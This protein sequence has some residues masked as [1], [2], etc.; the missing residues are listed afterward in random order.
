[1]TKPTIIFVHGAWHTSGFFEKTIA[2]VRP[3]GYRCIA[4]DLPAVGSNPPVTSL[5]EDIGPIR[6]AVVQEVELGHEVIIHAHSWGGIPT[7]S[8]LDGLS[9]TERQELK[10]T[11][12]VL[13]ITF[14]SS[15]VLP[16]GVSL[17]QAIG[18]PALRPDWWLIAE[19][20]SLN[21]QHF[22]L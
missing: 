13:K 22:S 16:V 15:F 7:T 1:M 2:L 14:V 12:G 18:G 17:E 19:D 11:G 5:T 8:A 9:S 6:A 20:V 21:R 4:V 10:K 3:L